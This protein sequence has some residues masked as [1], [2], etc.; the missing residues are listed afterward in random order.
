[1]AAPGHCRSVFTR[2]EGILYL[3]M[4]LPMYVLDQRHPARI[5]DPYLRCDTIEVKPTVLAQRKISAP[6]DPP[7]QNPDYTVVKHCQTGIFDDPTLLFRH[8]AATSGD[9]VDSKMSCNYRSSEL[10]A[11]SAV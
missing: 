11:K 7:G 5:G 1:M 6:D 3:L 9:T 10:L 8:A 2:P 4:E